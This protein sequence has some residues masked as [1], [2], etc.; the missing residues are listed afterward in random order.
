LFHEE[1][2]TAAVGFIEWA[3]IHPGIRCSMIKIL[4]GG[5]F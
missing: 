3:L 2:L 4:Q 5:G 1:N